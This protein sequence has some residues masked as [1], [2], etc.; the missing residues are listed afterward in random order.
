MP[1]TCTSCGTT[2]PDE[3]VFCPT[4]GSSLRTDEVGADLIG[5]VIAERYLVNKLLGEGGMG[6][7]YLAKHV[8]LP[9]QVAIKVLHHDMVKDANAVA[10]FNREAANAATIEHERVA[11]VFDFGQTAD[12]LV[13]LAMEF[14]PG[15]TLRDV[16]DESP[17]LHPVRAANIT[18]Q[19]AEGLDAAHRLSIV[20]RDLKPDN[21]LVITDEGGVDRCKVVDFGIAKATNDSGTQLTQMGMLVGTP[22]YMSPEQVLGE[23]L[24]GRSDLYALALVAFEMF[25]GGLPF[26][27]S[28]PERKL[29]AR[30]IQDPRTLAVVAPDVD[31][32]DALQAAF[33]RALVR[34]PENRTA[35]AMDFA[36]EIV[37]TVETWTE[38]SVLRARTPMSTLAIVNAANESTGA[39]SKPTPTS[40]PTSGAT[41]PTPA[42]AT[43]PSTT[44]STKS[45]TPGASTSASKQAIPEPVSKKSPLAAIAAAV[46]VVAAAGAYV[47]F[48][49]SGSS[50]ATTLPQTVASA[51]TP[52]ASPAAN[53]S[54]PASPT[55]PPVVPDPL[56]QAGGGSSAPASP[57]TPA[58]PT[59][60]PAG[61]GAA[62][63][64]GVAPGATP[65]APA[66]A[67][68]SGASEAETREARRSLNAINA[69]IQDA[70]D[71]QDVAVATKAIPQIMALLPRVGT[72]SDSTWVYIALVS[73][74]GLAGHPER[75]CEPYRSAKRLASLAKE[76]EALGLAGQSLT[77]AP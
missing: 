9:Q 49:R 77:C 26:E 58:R 28:T 35:T 46:L 66:G 75:A 60:S 23:Q 3:M 48:G 68:K 74:N 59:A 69:T 2:Y 22:E 44:A 33:D 42:K 13:Y 5:T 36:H 71:D 27:G 4:D 32:P 24:D 52:T 76:K 1:K 7:V 51:A 55:P 17:R 39:M 47:A 53:P 61:A 56:A 19:V 21:V 73:A 64:A 25:S 16:L 6:K 20:H 34:E 10:R 70:P 37:M 57:S 38:M 30:L 18:Y 50:N 72:A 29:T 45:P 12:G 65:V 40:S 15:K 11:R 63:T 67:A 54:A 14:V 62:A 41:R 8:R 31:W 43:P